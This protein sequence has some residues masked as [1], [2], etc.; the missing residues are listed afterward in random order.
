MKKFLHGMIALVL[1]F[2]EW[3][4][5]P[6]SAW[7]NARLSRI[8]PQVE[9]AILL[10][11]PYASLL[12]FA[13]PMILLLPA[14]LLVLYLFSI[15][16][17]VLGLMLLIATKL[18]GTALLAWLFHVTQPA[19][20]KLSWFAKWYPRWKAWKDHLLEQ[21]RSSPLWLAGMRLKQQAKLQL[22]AWLK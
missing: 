11:P 20:M 5:K 8:A 13:T 1:L 4:W 15:G 19:L 14:K 3:G 9:H 16:Q 21:V 18:I 22:D 12:V 6:L 10:L 2:E 17:M 7:V